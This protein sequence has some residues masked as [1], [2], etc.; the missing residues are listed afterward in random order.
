MCACCDLFYFFKHFKLLSNL[1][2]TSCIYNN[3]ASYDDIQSSNQHSGEEAD[4]T[5]CF[6]ALQNLHVPGS[7]ILLHLLILN[8]FISAYIISLSRWS[9]SS[10]EI[11][12]SRAFYRSSTC[13]ISY[14]IKL[15]PFKRRIST[16]VINNL[17]LF[18]HASLYYSLSLVLCCMCGFFDM[19]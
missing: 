8:V 12:N 10:W 4:E 16:A 18:S 6:H 17:Q 2:V 7:I 9:L 3:Q 11:E 15:N 5:H 14:L 13:S 19:T 1:S